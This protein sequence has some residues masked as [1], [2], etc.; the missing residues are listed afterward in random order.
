MLDP[1]ISGLVSREIEKESIVVFDE[2]HNIDNICIEVCMHVCFVY[3]S[4][5]MFVCKFVC[6]FSCVLQALF[7]TL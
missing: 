2:A 6:V 7:I 4:V 3:V 1:K 5:R